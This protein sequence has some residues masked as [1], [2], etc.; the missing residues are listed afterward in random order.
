[1][2]RFALLIAALLL[3][4]CGAR[5]VVYVYPVQQG[6]YTGGYTYIPAT[7]RGQTFT[8]PPHVRKCWCR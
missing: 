6:Y 4:G 2:A 3:T 5:E 1:M 7:V 8:I